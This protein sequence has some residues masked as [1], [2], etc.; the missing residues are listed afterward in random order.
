MSLCG[1]REKKRARGWFLERKKRRKKEKEKP[2]KTQELIQIGEWE[3]SE[4][5][6]KGKTDAVGFACLAAFDV[7]A[8]GSSGHALQEA[9]ARYAGKCLSV[10]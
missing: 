6:R 2:I 4:W 5:P 1:D 3:G 7:E 9:R 10:P 8:Q